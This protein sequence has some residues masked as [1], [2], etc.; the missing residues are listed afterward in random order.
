VG[1]SQVGSDKEARSAPELT[2]NE[3]LEVLNQ[4][5]G[6][7]ATA[8]ENTREA[9]RRIS[10][11]S[12]KEVICR[13]FSSATSAKPF[14]LTLRGAIARVGAH[15][16]RFSYLHL[17]QINLVRKEFGE[18]VKSRQDRTTF[19]R[20]YVQFHSPYG[21]L[22]QPGWHLK[23]GHPRAFAGPNHKF[24]LSAGR[25]RRTGWWRR[26]AGRLG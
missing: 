21:G 8:A 25:W 2:A 6:R 9:Q 3:D 11:V 5:Q 17:H 1:A 22:L 10:A 26:S 24:P 20:A 19:A 7:R 14:L 12:S 18:P 4:C 23:E 15:R 13:F 16:W